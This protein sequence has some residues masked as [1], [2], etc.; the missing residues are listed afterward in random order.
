MAQRG[1]IPC[2]NNMLVE[3]TEDKGFCGP[4][5]KRFCGQV[6]L[7]NVKEKSSVLTPELLRGFNILNMQCGCSREEGI[8]MP[9]SCSPPT[10]S[11]WL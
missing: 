11:L 2:P 10:D 4:V 8:M 6:K 1:H 7:G 5:D 9:F 3:H